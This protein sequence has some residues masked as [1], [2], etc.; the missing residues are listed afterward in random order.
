MALTDLQ[1][2]IVNPYAKEFD[3]D[4]RRGAGYSYDNPVNIYV[5]D[6]IHESYLY[7]SVF[8]EIGTEITNIGPPRSITIEDARAYAALY[9]QNTKVASVEGSP[10]LVALSDDQSRTQL[11]NLVRRLGLDSEAVLQKYSTDTTELAFLP[12][13]QEGM[14]KKIANLV[15]IPEQHS[16]TYK[17]KLQS[18]LD[19]GAAPPLLDI[20]DSLT[21]PPVISTYIGSDTNV[22]LYDWRK[23]C[24][25]GTDT[26]RVYYN[27]TDKNFYFTQRM[28]RP[29]RGLGKLN[30]IR[31]KGRSMDEAERRQKWNSLPQP[32]RDT[33]Q[34]LFIA[35]VVEILKMTG[36]YSPDNVEAISRPPPEGVGLPPDNFS[37]YTYLNP[38]PGS[39][40]T[41]AVK[42]PGSLIAVL[43]EGTELETLRPSYEEFEISSYEKSRILIG[44][45]NKSTIRF[46]F[47]LLDLVVY[48][49][50]TA[51]LVREYAEKLAN[52]G[53]TPALISNIDLDNEGSLLGSFLD[54]LNMFYGYNKLA[55]QDD[56]HVEFFMDE[57]Y[58]LDHICINGKFYYQGCGNKNYINTDQEVIR[59][60]NAFSVFTPTTFSIIKNSAKIYN[61]AINTTEES[62]LPAVE[63]IQTYL[64]PPVTLDA[65]EAQAAIQKQTQS[66]TLEE[67]KVI[68][69]TIQRLTGRQESDILK[70]FG[71][72][73]PYYAVTNTLQEVNCNTGQAQLLKNVLPIW[74]AIIGKVKVRTLIKQA[75]I[76]LRDEVVDDAMTAE[77]MT[78]AAGNVQNP[79]RVRQDIE[80]IVNQQIFCSL[81]AVGDFVERS[82]LDPL[83]SPPPL[84]KLTRKSLDK[85][86]K[87]KLPTYKM[88]SVKAK[89]SDYY[90]IMFKTVLEN[91]LRS[92]LT[93]VV[94]DFVGAILGCSPREPEGTL[95]TPLKRFDY[96]MVNLESAVVPIDIV[97]I[98]KS[99]NLV[100]EE[101]D[102]QTDPTVVQLR[103]LVSDV[104]NMST[105][106]ELDQLL[107]G[108][109]EDEYLQHILE[110]VSAGIS[111]TFTKKVQELGGVKTISVDLQPNLYHNFK[112][113]K[114]KLIDFFIAV[115]NSI[116]GV[117]IDI[118]DV[119]SPLDA[120]C[121]SKESLLDNLNLQDFTPEEIAA[122]YQ[123]IVDDKI[124]HINGL[125]DW[126]RGLQN[127][128]IELRRLIDLFPMLDYYNGLLREIA[129]FS[130]ML[131]AKIAAAFSELF[132]KSPI[133]TSALSY[134]LY[135]TKLGVDL[136]YQIFF[137]LRNI[138]I[139]SLYSTNSNTYGLV[140]YFVCPPGL[141][142]S[143]RKA[144]DGS[145]YTI[146]GSTQTPSVVVSY[147]WSYRELGAGIVNEGE[148][149]EINLTA[150]PYRLRLPQYTSPIQPPFDTYDAAYYSFR[151]GPGPLSRRLSHVEPLALLP[152]GARTD[153]HRAWLQ[154]N[155]Q[156]VFDYLREEQTQSPHSGYT[157]YGWLRL[158]ND[159]NSNVRI[160]K[161][162]PADGGNLTTVAHWR[163][164]S[165]SRESR[166]VETYA[167]AVNYNIY[168]RYLD[169]ENNFTHGDIRLPSVG[170]SD[171]K[172]L[173]A[174]LS[175]GK[176]SFSNT[177]LPTAEEHQ[178][179]K[180]LISINNYTERI[181]QTINNAVV[182]DTGRR[183]MPS[184]IAALNK[185]SL[186]LLKDPCVTPEDLARAQ[187]GIL[188]LQTRM[189]RF[190]LNTMPLARV[191][192]NWGSLG[193][194][195]MVTDYLTR[196]FSNELG[197]R[198]IL[199]H[200][201][202]T[203]PY[204]EKVF[205]HLDEEGYR[206]NPLI[207]D[208]NLP[209]QNLKNIIKAIYL[210]MLDNIAETSEYSA[211]NT[212]IFDDSVLGTDSTFDRY[213][214]TLEVFFNKIVRDLADPNGPRFGLADD[215]VLAARVIL[216]ACLG[217]DQGVTRTG[218]EIGTYYLPIALIYANYLIYYDQAIKFS[219][220]YSDT[221]YKTEVETATAD[222]V[223]L[224]A[225]QEHVVNR[226]TNRY[227]GFPVSVPY[228]DGEREP[229]YYN[230]TQVKER[231]V[232]VD[233]DI[234]RG[235]FQGTLLSQILDNPW[236][237]DDQN[238]QRWIQ[239]NIMGAAISP[240]YILATLPHLDPGNPDHRTR[241]GTISTQ[242]QMRLAYQATPPQARAG[243]LSIWTGFN[244]T[245]HPLVWD[246]DS[247]EYRN[248]G[249]LQELFMLFTNSTFRD[250][251]RNKSWQYVKNGDGSGSTRANRLVSTIEEFLDYPVQLGEPRG[252]W[253]ALHP[254]HR[255]SS[256][257]YR[258]LE[259]IFRQ[260]F[261]LY[262]P[263]TGI[264][265]NPEA[266]SDAIDQAYGDAFAVSAISVIADHY[267]DLAAW[268]LSSLREKSILEKLIITT[269]NLNE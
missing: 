28:A 37:V 229:V 160:F 118:G 142:S 208:N 20:E 36:K 82:F 246:D 173:F 245:R 4:E 139:T 51:P 84:K 21:M 180:F 223:L 112:F 126:M 110:T 203:F 171:I 233:Q 50:H 91:F 48:M 98:A 161:N 194:I 250:G 144:A 221:Y 32:T 255:T 76:L 125:C 185:P 151:N 228:W 80:N 242:A 148:E 155:S 104:S 207:L 162:T 96:G 9:P 135:H 66:K 232:V 13:N 265:P 189:Q 172:K 150:T 105:P 81:G 61:E 166:Q 241:A 46:S 224:S 216:D 74:G 27:A 49:G 31:I 127:V 41:Y 258:L 247:D 210:G 12:D 83:G 231:L 204:I 17:L 165:E 88:V 14:N 209:Q 89:Q 47:R 130:N 102:A 114:E 101:G 103:Q 190:F 154:S 5:L 65:I 57:N 75:I 18:S 134:N 99:V 77:V 62:R 268:N 72:R 141:G 239:H 132:G 86:I 140:P 10:R 257:Y 3:H 100:N 220:R 85:P 227:V 226:F 178:R 107:V 262:I 191:Y 63:F 212:S 215:E 116:D 256:E 26:E 35:G 55:P 244:D 8:P 158:G 30:S 254:T 225:F 217:G 92:L 187:A 94:K 188:T 174:H 169:T 206:N 106:L 260:Y 146:A 219:E 253:L 22:N 59:S 39:L 54:Y 199:G 238:A 109:S 93:A 138:P 64:H 170:N 176:T 143:P 33:Y 111:R 259:S 251:F 267:K 248:F 201:Y 243:G 25:P 40:W 58:I 73:H 69:Q 175:I 23:N 45:N 263:L 79:D 124:A 164:T 214:K 123:D 119:T 197:D 235:F 147:I 192:G 137:E 237:Q 19:L 234:Q 52:E 183:R 213:L 16:R 133:N 266:P 269:D 240:N 11:E 7:F 222:D 230:S 202:K 179:N 15:A 218:V 177:D 71:E 136:F 198:K 159:A 211:I 108:D 157:G 195:E 200:L 95:P 78:Y 68:F 113:T 264:Q 122:Q 252:S 24:I 129:A 167:H 128:E 115:G 1:K 156:V 29:R 153:A 168:N 38:R 56:D 87:I 6:L 2:K 149:N 90:E 163:P 34:L 181:D 70:R 53:I 44:E 131:S 152:S 97:A 182:S 145:A 184:Y 261:D 42:I 196:K 60:T 193:T 249:L 186:E 67:M 120:Y 117:N 236:A 205:P 43:P 121:D